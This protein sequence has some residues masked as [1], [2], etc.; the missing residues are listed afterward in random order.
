MSHCVLC[1][2]VLSSVFVTCY[3]PTLTVEFYVLS[4]RF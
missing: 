4:F 2:N 3:F 1:K